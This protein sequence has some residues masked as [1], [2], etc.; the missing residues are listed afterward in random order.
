MASGFWRV[1]PSVPFR[2]GIRADRLEYD[3]EVASASNP[4]AE[5]SKIKISRAEIMKHRRFLIEQRLDV[6]E[7]QR[8]ALLHDNSLADPET[9]CTQLRGLT[10]IFQVFVAGGAQQSLQPR[11]RGL[12]HGDAVFT[13]RIFAAGAG[14]L[15][16]DVEA[17]QNF[18]HFLASIGVNH[19]GL[20]TLEREIH[21]LFEAKLSHV[22]HQTVANEVSR[23]LFHHRVSIPPLLAAEPL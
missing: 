9:F 19:D 17:N 13:C 2:S 15:K 22:T 16:R 4:S 14:R 11:F 12:N 20:T 23:L 3:I 8:P 21:R 10:S 1:L 5:K 6:K 7:L 18:A